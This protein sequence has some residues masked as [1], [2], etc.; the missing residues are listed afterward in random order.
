M[1][2]ESP[3]EA[4]GF[5]TAGGVEGVEGDGEDDDSLSRLLESALILDDM[6]GVRDM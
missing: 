6:V 2:V 3:E 5:G 4:L 1:G